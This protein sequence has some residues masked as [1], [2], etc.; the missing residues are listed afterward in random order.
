MSGESDGNWEGCQVRTRQKLSSGFYQHV[1]V[2]EHVADVPVQDGRD[3]DGHHE[4]K[5]EHLRK[6]R[7]SVV[8]IH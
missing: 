7:L 3:A 4:L 6:R 1:S 8:D 5:Q 2:L